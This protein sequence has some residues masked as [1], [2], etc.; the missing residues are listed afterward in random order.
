MK[1]IFGVIGDPIEHSISPIMQNAAFDKMKMDCIYLAFHVKAKDVKEAVFGAKSL[2]ISGLNVTIPHKVRVMDLL[3]CDP[4]AKKIGAVNTIDLSTNMGY[5]TDGLG[6]KKALEA[7]NVDVFEKKVV[8]VGSGGAAKAISFQLAIDGAEI[9]IVNR[10]KS[11]AI[12]IAKSIDSKKVCGVGLDELSA[13]VKDADILINS[14]SVGMYPNVDDSLLTQ[15][16]IHSGLVVFDVV[17]NPIE[18]KLLKEAKKAG[19]K[20]IDGVM[21]LVHQG[22]E[23]FRIWTGD[24]PPVDEMEKAVRG[25]LENK[26]E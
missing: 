20:T 1:K 11:K 3:D 23:S 26:N 4:L 5:N 6:A 12:D 18:T 19:A 21:M 14:T 24:K 8:L 10:T 2:G 9:T 13:N 15:E 7:H 17:Y 22:A 16:M 25:V